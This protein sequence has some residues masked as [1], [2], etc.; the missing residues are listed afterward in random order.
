M[1]KI[2]IIWVVFVAMISSAGAAENFKE[3]DF[4][5]QNVIEV[6]GEQEAGR[7]QAVRIM[8]KWYLTA[9]HCVLPMCSRDCSVT[10]QLLQGNL[11]AFVRV[12]HTASNARVFV[13]ASYFPSSDRSIRSDIALIRFDPSAEEFFYSDIKEERAL[14]EAT[15]KK[16]LKESAH[17]SQRYQWDKLQASRPIIYSVSNNITRKLTY[18]I[19][20]PDLRGGGLSVYQSD[21]AFY[22]FPQLRY[23]MGWNF[24]VGRGMSGGGV[25]LPGGRLVGVVS[26]RLAQRGNMMLYNEQDEPIDSVPYSSEY[27]L[28]TPISQENADFIRATVLSFHEPGFLPALDDLPSRYY[29][30]TTDK[31]K[32]IF[33]D[34]PAD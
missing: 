3:D 24:G 29:Q 23:Y 19:A 25:V 6:V 9:A 30:Q 28:F 4:L 20:V 12:H 13:P 7:C 18:P 15:F 34:T 33:V 16:K 17:A 10:V 21:S 26:T 11:Q 27:F 1:K 5:N 8:P 14:D 2:F 22:Y 32:D 31:V